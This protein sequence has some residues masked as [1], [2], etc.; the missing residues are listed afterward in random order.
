MTSFGQTN[1]SCDTIYNY[2]GKLAHYIDNEKGLM[3]YTTKTL[4]PILGD[5]I[6]QDGEIIAS[7]YLIL[8]ID[9][10]GKVIAVDFTPLTATENCKD[11]LRKEIMNMTG[12]APGQING[13][14]VCS[15]FLWPTSCLKWR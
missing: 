2:P 10:T 5:C 11:K 3:E 1:N 9:R 7:M 13:K 15:I 14:D 4:A 8:T 12:W 6:K